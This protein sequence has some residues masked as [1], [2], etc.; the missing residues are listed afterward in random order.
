MV[1]I[2]LLAQKY[3][4]TGGATAVYIE[5]NVWTV[6]LLH[7]VVKNVYCRHRIVGGSFGGKYLYE[8]RE[9]IDM[10]VVRASYKRKTISGKLYHSV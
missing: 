9:R 2:Q 4:S 1:I 6:F 10:Y 8:R 5:E 3:E 7:D